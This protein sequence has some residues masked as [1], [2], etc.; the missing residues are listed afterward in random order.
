VPD[1]E[2]ERLPEAEDP[3]LPSGQIAE[4]GEMIVRPG[5]GPGVAGASPRG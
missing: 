5:T 1:E 3:N 2:I 4:A